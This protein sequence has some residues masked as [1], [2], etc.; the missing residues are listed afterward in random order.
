MSKDA[1]AGLKVVAF[2]WLVTGPVITKFLADHG[3]TVIKVESGTRPELLRVS[4]PYKDGKVDPNTSGYFHL[5]NGNE[6]SVSLNL[7]QPEGIAVA[8]RLCR[9]ADLVIEN[10]RPG[11]LD[12]MGL[13]YADLKKDNPRLVMLSATMMGQSGP[14]AQQPG[15]GGQMVSYAGF[16]HVTGW[17]DRGPTQ[18]Y[19]AYTDFPA[20]GLATPL[21][22]AALLRQRETGQGLWIDLSQYETGICFLAPLVLDC[23]A[24]GRPGDRQGNSCEYA[25]PHGVYPC[26]GEEAWIAIAV[27][28]DREWQALCRVAALPELN[29]PEFDTFRGRKHNESRLDAILSKWTAGW[30]KHEL[31]AK[32]QAEGVDAGAVQNGRDVLEDPHL[33]GR[34]F[35]WK[36]DS[37]SV[38][39]FS[40]LG[41]PFTLSDTPARPRMPAPALGEH[42]EH[43]CCELLGM[44]SDEFVELLAKGAF[45]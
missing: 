25:C 18:P 31:M 15:I 17:A 40:Y 19:G 28:E 7:N 35:F 16:T 11:V 12:R 29:A 26:R 24:N 38:G 33:K 32:L 9:W 1:F 44:S 27:F 20:P 6:L 10:F 37:P 2:T 5:I 13:G 23:A 43:V 22:L 39:P 4:P 14:Y 30:D 36:Q 34:H 41:E 8:R 3:A 42:T 45:E 21:L